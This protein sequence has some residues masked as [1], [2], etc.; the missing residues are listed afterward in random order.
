MRGVSCH[1]HLV[2]APDQR[3]GGERAKG[4]LVHIG[5]AAV[6]L[7]TLRVSHQHCGL[8]R[9]PKLRFRVS[10]QYALALALGV[11]SEDRRQKTLLRCFAFWAT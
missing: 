7:D 1:I 5:I 8:E 11:G 10:I 9:A 4:G 6:P 3:W 2:A